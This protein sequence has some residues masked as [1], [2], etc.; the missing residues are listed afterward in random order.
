MTNAK[1][2]INA[3]IQN[4]EDERKSLS[5]QGI[6]AGHRIYL[7]NSIQAQAE[8]SLTLLDDCIVIRKSDV[9]EGLVGDM[10]NSPY[11]IYKSRVYW[12]LE[13]S[14]WGAAKLL[15]EQM[16]NKDA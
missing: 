3:I 9:P 10:I 11:S 8:Q 15:A 12:K 7:I 13:E 5:K 2:Q 1:E 4:C 14:I 16:E 6:T